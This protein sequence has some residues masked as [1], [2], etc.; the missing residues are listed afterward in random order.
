MQMQQQ[1]GPII[2]GTV[3]STNQQPQGPILTRPCTD[4]MSKKDKNKGRRGSHSGS[5]SGS[6]SD[7]SDD[8]DRERRGR[9]GSRRGS[10]SGSEPTQA[11]PTFE[12]DDTLPEG[13]ISAPNLRGW[14]CGP[15]LVICAVKGEKRPG[16]KEDSSCALPVPVV[17]CQKLKAEGNNKLTATKQCAPPCPE[18]PCFCSG[19]GDLPSVYIRVPGEGGANYFREMRLLEE[20]EAAGKYQRNDAVCCATPG[21]RFVASG[22]QGCHVGCSGDPQGKSGCCVLVPCMVRI[23]CD[24]IDTR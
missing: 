24:S 9:R 14:W 13:G 6:D 15:G 1:H 11:Q 20:G 10:H 4:A 16:Q 3:V 21:K 19:R 7:S 23:P 5:H 2:Q 12:L 22:F 17:F 18:W 8:D